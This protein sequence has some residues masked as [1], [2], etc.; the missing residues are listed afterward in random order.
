M[1]V[2]ALNAR[3][4]YD[5]AVKIGKLALAEN[6]TL[7]QA[8]EKLG[9]VAPEDFDPWVRPEQMIRPGA[10]LASGG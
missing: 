9:Y 8:A 5:K 10:T 3:I 6:V 7:K 1:L 2:T 4:D